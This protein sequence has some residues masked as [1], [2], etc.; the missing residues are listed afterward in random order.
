MNKY[1]NKSG[2]TLI[3][4]IVVLIIV[5]ILAAIA[6]PN[7]FQNVEKSHAAE[8]LSTLGIY[9]SQVEGCEQA[10]VD[11][12]TT[13]CGTFGAVGIPNPNTANFTVGLTGVPT[14]GATSSTL[15]WTL[16]ATYNSNTAD[17]ITMTRDTAGK[18]NCAGAAGT[19]FAGVC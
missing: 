17:I 19:A 15:A 12:T 18:I 4:I 10:H 6:L 8:A 5:G 16:T 1:N 13:N 7:L 2:F 14:D 3:E 11:K 9:K